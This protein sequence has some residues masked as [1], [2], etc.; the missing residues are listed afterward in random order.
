VL[1]AAPLATTRLALSDGGAIPYLS[2]LWTL[3]LTGLDDTRIAISRDRAP[4]SVFTRGV[5]VLVLVSRSAVRFAPADWN[6]WELPIYEE[7][8]RRGFRCLAQWR[9]ADDYRLW[10]M[11]R[12]DETARLLRD[13]GLSGAESCPQ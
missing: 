8:R 1:S 3:D 2:R 13:T 6:R 4:A 9:F 12:S 5:N 7:A 11:V 10:L